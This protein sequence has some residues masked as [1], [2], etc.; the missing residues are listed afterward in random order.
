MIV[1]LIY[2]DFLETTILPPKI[3]GQFWISDKQQK[4]L[5]S[6]EGIDGEWILKSNNKIKFLNDLENKKSIVLEERKLYRLYNKITKTKIIIFTEPL[7]QDRISFEKYMIKK[8]MNI[9]IGSGKNICCDIEYQNDFV[10]REHT[11]LIYKN[12]KW[13]LYDC[14]SKNGTFVNKQKTKDKELKYGDLVCIMGCKVIVSKGIIAINNPDDKVKINSLLI[15][16]LKKSEILLVDEVEDENEE[17]EYFERPPRFMRDIK[18]V[19]INIDSPPTIGKMDNMPVMLSMGPALTMGMASMTTGLYAVN[20]AIINGNVKTAI[21]SIVMSSSMLLGTVLWPTLTR[22]YNS[23]KKKE[24]EIL[25]KTK[26]FEYLEN[27]KVKIE[28]E[29]EKQIGILNE[30]NTDIENAIERI[31]TCKKT[32]WERTLNHSDF[33]NLRLGIADIPMHGKLVYDVK[34]FSIESDELEEKMYEICEEPKILKDV[35]ITLSLLK[36]KICGVVGETNII[37]EYI[38]GIILQIC[39]MHSYDEVKFIFIMS[40]SLEEKFR[41]LKWLPYVWNNEKTFRNLAYTEE[42]AKEISA[43]LDKIISIRENM[44]ESEL[45]DI[46]T[47]YI[48]FAF[49]KYLFSKCDATKRILNQKKNLNISI[50]NVFSEFKFLPKECSKVIEITETK[51]R[52]FNRDDINQEYLEFKPDLV[53]N[54]PSS[55]LS[56]KLSNIKLNIESTNSFF[57]K[58]ISFLEMFDVGKVEHLN[59]YTRWRENNPTKSL[60]TP[61]GIDDRGGLFNLDLHEKFHGP[62]GLVAGMTGSGKSEFI[63]T[64]IL[65][66]AVN[67]HP[68]EIAFILIDYK[69]GGM[70]KAFEKLPHIAGIITNLDGSAINRSLIS[71]NSELKRR[72]K[73]FTEASLILG[74]SNINIYQYQKMYR[75]KLVK[76]PLQ[77]LFIISDEFAE[78]K[79]QRPEFMTELVSAARIGRSLGIHLILATQKPSGIVDDQ[80]WSNSR[81]RVCLKVQERADSMDMLK[82]P[83]AAE[84]SDTGR[85]YLQVGYNELFEMG[86]ASWAGSDYIPADKVIKEKNESVSV[87]DTNGRVVKSVKPN[88]FSQSTG[89]KSKQID[90][91]TEY[92]YKLADEEKVHSKPLWLE[93]IKEF[94]YIDELKEKYGH[95]KDLKNNILNPIIGEY[96][97]PAMQKQELLTLPITQNGNTIIYGSAGK[98]KNEFL[99]ILVYSLIVDYT[100]IQIN[101]YILDFADETLKAFVTAPHVGEVILSY[102]KE[103]VFNLF[104]MLNKEINNRKKILANLGMSFND[105]IKNEDSMTSIVVII[106]NYSAFSELYPEA[107]EMITYITRDGVKY[108]VYFVLTALTTNVIKYR[109]MQNFNLFY[110]LQLN[111]S[112][113]YSNVVGKTNGL[114]PEKYKGRGLFKSDMIYEFQVAYLTDK[115]NTYDFIKNK[116]LELKQKWKGNSAERV[117]ILPSNVDSDFLKDYIKD[118]DKLT[119]PIGISK[120]TLKPYHYNLEERYINT[121]YSSNDSYLNFIEELILLFGYIPNLNLVIFNVMNYIKTKSNYNF[122]MVEN[123][124]KCNEVVAN[125]FDIVLNRNNTYK[126][127]I[128]Q[129]TEVPCFD[130]KVIVITELNNLR[131]ILSDENKEKLDLILLKGDKKYNIFIILADSIKEVRK[132]SFSSWY[133]TH[134]TKYDGIWI[135]EGVSEQYE[136]KTHKVEAELRADIDET[137]GFVFEKGKINLLKILSCLGEKDG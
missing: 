70:A 101:L 47:H 119:L 61:I 11:K 128:E 121:I 88:V 92:L 20:N 118:I 21:P 102:E 16:R 129:K 125:L 33:L 67:Y 107:E 93:P 108:G 22:K 77:H 124:E 127:A 100:P 106:N 113:E 137:F 35:P 52:I 115:K 120:H 56:I 74:E 4:T 40:A 36:D 57:Y 133:T 23:K 94:I 75:E 2:G 38:I 78:L 105:F 122:Q 109:L 18:Y 30:N 44:N 68:N 135:G 26:Y 134:V 64:Y 117:P 103:K 71:I 123:K 84:L 49:D 132:Y 6:I 98:G 114:I 41:F 14:D 90:A 53:P 43:N 34:K 12:E 130:K 66:L 104:K 58:T 81:F 13:F 95:K 80:I 1:N 54:I 136:L 96:D 79:T 110:T 112:S 50:V 83:D 48:I 24:H 82:R 65:S 28:K 69:G 15:E 126:D 131:E 39:A 85:F 8:E 7:T 99:N 59:S 60:A 72:Q 55:N 37:Y 10:S 45:K 17:E 42:E 27:C 29:C 31:E 89:K 116:C 63:I 76:E 5:V 87:I 111:D 62:H 19:E 25:W 51:G 91:V 9:V 3:K 97:N 73:L 46:K 86:Q 32:L